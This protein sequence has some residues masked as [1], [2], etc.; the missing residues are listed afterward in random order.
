MKSGEAQQR[1]LADSA[2]M[3]AERERKEKLV[4]GWGGEVK[5]GGRTGDGLGWSVAVYAGMMMCGRE[6]EE[7]PKRRLV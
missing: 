4:N 5:I 6:R 2:G 7:C 1:Q 3:L